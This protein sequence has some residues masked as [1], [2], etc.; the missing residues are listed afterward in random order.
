VQY[1]L[2][3]A[4]VLQFSITSVKAGLPPIGAAPEE[5]CKQEC[6][7]SNIIPDSCKRAFQN[8]DKFSLDRKMFNI[9]YTIKV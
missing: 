7:T 5:S 1:I 8:L 3:T 2:T 4:L 6:Q 9:F